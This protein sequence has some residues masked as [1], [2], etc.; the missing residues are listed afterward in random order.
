MRRCSAT[1]GASQHLPRPRRQQSREALEARRRWSSREKGGNGS[2]KSTDAGGAGCAARSRSR[3]RSR[4]QPGGRF[5]ARV[6]SS[7]ALV[8]APGRQWERET[9]RE[10]LREAARESTRPRLE[11]NTLPPPPPPRRPSRRRHALFLMGLPGAG[12]STVK[13]HRLR[14]G[15]LD[16]EPDRFKCRHPRFSERMSDETDDEVHRW[17]VRRSVDAFEDAIASPRQPN[18]VFDSSGSNGRWLKRRIHAARA[19]GYTTELLWVDVPVEIA[20]L[21]NRDRAARQ[22]CPEKVIMDKA[23]V[24]PLSFH[25]LQKE[26][27]SAERLQNWSERNEEFKVAKD[28]IYFYPAPRSHPPSLRPGN[29]GYGEPP[30][31]ARSPS[32]G[33]NSRRTVRIGPWKRNDTVMAEKNARLSWIDRTFRGDRERYVLD[34][35]LCGRDTMV[36]PNRFP[37]MLP[38]GIEHWII[39][40]LRPMGHTELCD[41]IEGWLDAR[42]PHDV[43]AWNYDDNRGRRTID[44]WHVHIYFQGNPGKTPFF[45]RGSGSRHAARESSHR[46]PCSV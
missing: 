13:R 45:R 5:G 40:S 31:G 46:S 36:E 4:R 34:R 14:E 9:E 20:L 27:D 22:W 7:G 19:E 6:C 38:P 23:S 3:S 8:L 2:L 25:E 16:I 17:S 35:V 41:Y 39:W 44:V 10:A 32:R 21:R 12:K 18:L 30:D 43:T 42:E 37:Y 26:V 15:D 24:L 29:R 28:D 11:R 1:Q 33:A